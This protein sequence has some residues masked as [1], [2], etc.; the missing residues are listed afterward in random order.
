[1]QLLPS[2][3]P[4]MKPNAFLTDDTDSAFVPLGKVVEPV[5][6]VEREVARTA[7]RVFRAKD[8]FEAAVPESVVERLTE[9]GRQAAPNEWYGLVVG[10]LYQDKAGSHAIVL[11]VVP[12]TE[13]RAGLASVRTTAQSE[14]R[15]RFTAQVLFPDCV[16]LGWAHTHPRLGLCFSGTDRVNQ[17]TWTRPHSLGLVVDPW[18]H[19]R[20][21]VYRGPRSEL[22]DVVSGDDGG[23]VEAECTDTGRER[24][25]DPP[26]MLERDQVRAAP[27]GRMRNAVRKMLALASAFAAVV[28]SMLFARSLATR[29]GA[30]ERAMA[31]MRPASS[32]SA[33]SVDAS[34]TMPTPHVASAPVDAAASSE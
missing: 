17:A 28:C 15:T 18:H 31:S 6:E 21:A 9:F 1:M 30:I 11:G 29:I 16:P 8:G 33:V 20:I 10:K 22:L 26:R 23:E 7:C 25:T 3:E 14:F 24:E 27:R 13:C 12:D 4:R 32:A 5:H 19:R 2:Q 34:V